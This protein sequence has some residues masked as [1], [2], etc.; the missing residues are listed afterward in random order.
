[1]IERLEKERGKLEGELKRSNGMLKN[2]KFLSK[3]PAQKIEEEKAKLEKYLKLM[4][5]VTERLSQLK[6]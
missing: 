1:E 5:Q 3:A 2:E 4:D 6:K